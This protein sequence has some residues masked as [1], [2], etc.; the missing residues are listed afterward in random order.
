MKHSKSLTPR[1]KVSVERQWS[2]EDWLTEGNQALWETLQR[3]QTHNRRL[4]N[5][6]LILSIQA[7]RIRAYLF[8]DLW[9]H[10]DTQPEVTIQEK[11]KQGIKRLSTEQW[12]Q[13]DG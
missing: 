6:P 4:P 1:N 13:P 12:L 8:P 3:A 5:S 10:L 7:G 9:K 2:K 11:W